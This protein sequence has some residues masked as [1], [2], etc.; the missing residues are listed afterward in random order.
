LTFY[1]NGGPVPVSVHVS[2]GQKTGLDRT[3]KHYPQRSAHQLAVPNLFALTTLILYHP[4][5][6]IAP[7]SQIPSLLC[8]CGTYTSGPSHSILTMHHF[9]LAPMYNHILCIFLQC[10][11]AG[12]LFDQST[13]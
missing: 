1:G 5:A 12:A 3:F 10:F 4:A 13:G 11:S 8:V 6:L 7:S 2:E 9:P